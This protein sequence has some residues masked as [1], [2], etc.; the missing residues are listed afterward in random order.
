MAWY[1]YIVSGCSAGRVAARFLIWGGGP[2]LN[3]EFLP[4]LVRPDSRA[5]ALLCLGVDTDES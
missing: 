2:P 1:A 5:V 4:F 3:E